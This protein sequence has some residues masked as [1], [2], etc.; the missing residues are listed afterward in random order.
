MTQSD[1]FGARGLEPKQQA[2]ARE[3]R[4]QG[5]QLQRVHAKVGDII[6]SFVVARGLRLGDRTFTMA[7]LLGVVSRARPVAPASADRILRLLRQ[8][9]HLNYRVVDRAA[10]LYEVLP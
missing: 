10:S 6:L 3:K 7:E 2:V 4:E 8:E 1:L 9:G 5:K